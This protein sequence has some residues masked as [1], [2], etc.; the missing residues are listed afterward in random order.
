MMIDGIKLIQRERAELALQDMFIESAVENGDIIDM[1]MEGEVLSEEEI[2]LDHPKSTSAEADPVIMDLLN[3]LPA[4]VDDEAL[5][6]KLIN[7]TAENTELT[8]IVP[9]ADPVGIEI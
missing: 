5:I 9:A 7:S 3:K 8:D 4:D 2:M 1:M 6:D